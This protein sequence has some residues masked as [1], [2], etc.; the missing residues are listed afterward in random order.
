MGI[1]GAAG[2]DPVSGR[3]TLLVDPRRAPSGVSRLP[4]VANPSYVA[5]LFSSTLGYLIVGTMA[6]LEA[7]GIVWMKRLVKI[8]V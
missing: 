8:E 7:V 5:P 1:P 2:E 3:P 4:T 6:V